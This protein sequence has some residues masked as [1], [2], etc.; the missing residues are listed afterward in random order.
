MCCGWKSHS[1]VQTLKFWKD[2]CLRKIEMTDLK[3]YECLLL[4]PRCHQLQNYESQNTKTYHKGSFDNSCSH[5]NY[6]F[7]LLLSVIWK[8]FTDCRHALIIAM[9]VPKDSA[10]NTFWNIT[11]WTRDRTFC[12][13][14]SGNLLKAKINPS[15]IS[16]RISLNF[17]RVRQPR[18]RPQHSLVHLTCHFM[19]YY[20]SLSLESHFDFETVINFFSW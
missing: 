18:Y 17:L 3:M 8:S 13:S 11:I 6:E 19:F 10:W 4:W 7:F 2:I 14:L 12:T 1:Q 9:T 15:H 5:Q 16:V 20:W